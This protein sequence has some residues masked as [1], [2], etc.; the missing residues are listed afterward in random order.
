[1][2]GESAMRQTMCGEPMPL[3]K[4]GTS[5]GICSRESGHRPFHGNGTC[6][7]CGVVLDSQNSSKSTIAKGSG[8]CGECKTVWARNRYGSKPRNI[9]HPGEHHVFPCGC[10]GVL[11]DTWGG[12]NKFA[13]R[14]TNTGGFGCR[15]ASILYGSQVSAKRDGNEPIPLNTPHSVIRNLMD[16]TD[17]ERCGELLDWSAVAIAGA[18]APH[19]HHNHFTGEPHGFTHPK[20]N[21]LAMEREI[22]N[23]RTETPEKL[24]SRAMSRWK[25][26]AASQENVRKLNLKTLPALR[27]WA[28]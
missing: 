27:R 13:T 11:P 24:L 23:F 14:A 28:K 10:S 9:Q 1:M 7:G 6:S 4:N 12:A 16:E 17:C 26:N 18:K 3:A 2:L 22:T 15:V 8:K 19:L 5:R 21:P 25:P 20:C